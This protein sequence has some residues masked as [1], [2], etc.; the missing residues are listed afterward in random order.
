MHAADAIHGD[1]GM[2]QQDDVV[3]M[4]SK[5]GDS[6]EIKVLVPIVKN[7]GNII[8]AMVGQTQSYLALHADVILNTTVS[9]EACPNNLAPTTSTTA[10]MVMGDALAICLMSKRGFS[11]DELAKFHPGGTL[12]KKLYL[13]V[14]DL[15]RQ[16]EKPTVYKTDLFSS[17]LR[18]SPSVITPATESSSFKTAVAPNLFLDISRI[19][20]FNKSVL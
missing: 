17:I 10:Q 19:T 5:S 20:S 7:F 9:N 16:N 13:K 3:M 14:A 18:K 6:P 8:I 1:I 12:G 15:C 4:I 11:S 2:I